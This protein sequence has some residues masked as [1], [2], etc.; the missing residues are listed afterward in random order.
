MKKILREKKNLISKLDPTKKEIAEV[1]KDEIFLVETAHHLFLYKEKL[2][3]N[4]LLYDL[5]KKIMNPLT[6]P[7]KVK[8]TNPWRCCCNKNIRYCL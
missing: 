6:G 8:N 3:E 4:D 1:E 5:P 7:I 2:C